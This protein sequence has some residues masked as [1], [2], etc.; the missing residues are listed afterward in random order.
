[1]ATKTNKQ[2]KIDATR[3]FYAAVGA[4]DAAVAF[5]RT[6]P[7]DVQTRVA[8]VEHKPKTQRDQAVT[9]VSTRVEDL[10]GDAKKA[11]AAFEA[12][13][14]EL[15]TDAKALPAKFEKLVNDY[16]AEL[17]KTVADLNKGYAELAARG[18]EFVTKVR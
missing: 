11:Q 3:P 8:K 6:P 10:Q 7:A 14:A 9:L 18:Q 16:L 17:N 12:R 4:G 1:M 15:Q 5:A 13:L 2:L